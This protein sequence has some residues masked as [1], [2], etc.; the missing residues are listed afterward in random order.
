MV[1]SCHG[2]ELYLLIQLPSLLP[3]GTLKSADKE[4][5]NYRSS[6]RSTVILHADRM[7]R[8]VISS[9]HNQQIAVD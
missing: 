9:H 2:P 1:G 3:N 4:V 6:L 5:G 8:Q 7:L